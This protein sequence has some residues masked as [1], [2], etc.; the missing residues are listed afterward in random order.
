MQIETR[1]EALNRDDGAGVS[2]HAVR[3][4]VVTWVSAQEPLDA[5]DHDFLQRGDQLCGFNSE[6]RSIVY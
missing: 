3:K 2:G 4:S 1:A 6:Y 5:T